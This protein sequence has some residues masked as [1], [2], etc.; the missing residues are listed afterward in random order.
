MPSEILVILLDSMIFTYQRP[1]P[2]KNAVNK[3]DKLL[4]SNRFGKISRLINVTTSHHG[5]VIGD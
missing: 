5:N 1:S 4:Y 2:S 3:A